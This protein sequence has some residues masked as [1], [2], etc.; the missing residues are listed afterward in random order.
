MF[1]EKAFWHICSVSGDLFAGIRERKINASLF[2]S[3]RYLVY[4]LIP[5]K[6]RDRVHGYETKGIFKHANKFA[7]FLM[8]CFNLLNA[9]PFV[10]NSD[11]IYLFP[12]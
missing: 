12:R 6:Y 7:F 3:G 10:T 8:C 11:Y 5:L 4:R 2:Y 1:V 9:S